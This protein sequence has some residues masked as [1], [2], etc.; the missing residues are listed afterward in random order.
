MAFRRI[1]SI[2]SR[3][4][5]D[6]NLTVKDIANILINNNYTIDPIQ[7]VNMENFILQNLEYKLNYSTSVYINYLNLLIYQI[8]K[9]AEI[10]DLGIQ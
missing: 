8:D 10:P 3:T 4:L 5:D 9:N 1:I 7:L 6:I 2:A